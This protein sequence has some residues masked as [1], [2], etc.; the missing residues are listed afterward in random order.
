[1]TNAPASTASANPTLPAASPIAPT[2]ATATIATTA[3]PT[4]PN[5]VTTAVTPGLGP[6]V[7]AILSGA[8]LAALIRRLSTSGSPVE[9]A[10]K[11]SATGYATASP[12]PSPPTA[13]T[14]N[15]PTPSVAD[16]PM[17][18]PRSVSDCPEHY[19]KSKLTLPTTSPE[20]RSSLKPWGR[21]V[22]ILSNR[23]AE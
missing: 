17:R 10:G 11:M 12:K 19:A 22:P 16:V 7:T 1:M 5:P 4:A 13:P 20:L 15:F 18:L 21:R 14:R 2:R 6:L 8:F 23:S 3:T 9:K